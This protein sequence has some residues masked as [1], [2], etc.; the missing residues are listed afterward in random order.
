MTNKT[1]NYILFVIKEQVNQKQFESLSFLVRIATS[2]CFMLEII[3]LKN[4]EEI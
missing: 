3:F 4:L 2:T 1:Q